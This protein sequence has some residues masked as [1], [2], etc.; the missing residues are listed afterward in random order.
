MKSALMLFGCS[1]L[2][3][4]GAARAQPNPQACMNIKTACE[5]AGFV[6][7]GGAGRN[8]RTDCFDHLKRGESVAGVLVNPQ[9]VTA[10]ENTILWNKEKRTD[11]RNETKTLDAGK[12]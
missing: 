2:L 6:I 8:L 11:L 12:F 10:C 5:A 4:A 9:D 7:D 1:M 3:S